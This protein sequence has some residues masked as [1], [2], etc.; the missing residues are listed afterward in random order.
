VKTGALKNANVPKFLL[1]HVLE[2]SPDDYPS[3]IRM[4][5]DLGVIFLTS[6]RDSTEAVLDTIEDIIALHP[7]VIF[8]L[9]RQRPPLDEKLWPEQCPEG[10]KEEKIHIEL[11]NCPPNLP[12]I[13]AAQIHSEGRCCYAWL[14]GVV[15]MTKGERKGDMI[16]IRADLVENSL[17]NGGDYL[18]L[19]VRTTAD[20]FGKEISIFNKMFAFMK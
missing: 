13:F 1:R 20:T 6:L 5:V 18:L 8:R 17:E 4:L 7:V 14:K 15:V 12:P 10:Q 11:P 19:A 16:R 2:L 9:P 3:I